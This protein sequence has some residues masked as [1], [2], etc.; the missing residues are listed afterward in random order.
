MQTAIEDVEY[1][2]SAGKVI[3][4]TSSPLAQTCQSTPTCTQVIYIP[5]PFKNPHFKYRMQECA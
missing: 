3:P 4:N 2:L 1:N 5:P